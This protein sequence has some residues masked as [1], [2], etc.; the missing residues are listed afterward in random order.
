MRWLSEAEVSTDNFLSAQEEKNRVAL[1]FSLNY[2]EPKYYKQNIGMDP[3]NQPV[4][5]YNA[6][7]KDRIKCDQTL[8]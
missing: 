2:N 3:F 8:T 5:R 7:F 1:L 6:C 4:E